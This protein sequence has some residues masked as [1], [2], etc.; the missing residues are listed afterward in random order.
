MKNFR[1]KVSPVILFVFIALPVFAGA[2]VEYT[3]RP[4]VTVQESPSVKIILTWPYFTS[5]SQYYILRKALADTVWADI[6]AVA[7][8]A[9]TWADTTAAVGTIYEYKISHGIANSYLVSA[10]KAPLVD[11]RG[12]VILIVDNTMTAPLLAEL[13]RLEQDLVGDGWTVIRHDVARAASVPSVKTLIV[14]DYNADP[15]NVKAVF[16]FGRVPVPYSGDINPDGHPDHLGA[17]PADVFYA[18]VDGTWTDTTV[19]DTG[20]SRAENKNIP[21]DGKYDQSYIPSNTELEIGRV[22]LANMTAFSKTETELLRQ[23]LDKDHNFRHGIISCQRRAL[24]DDEFGDIYNENFASSGWRNFASFFGASNV[25]GLDW[26]TTLNTNDY[27]CAYGCGGGNYTSASNVG[28][29]TDFVNTDTKVVFTMLFGSYF[30][31]WDSTNNFLRAPLCTTTY[32]LTCLWAGRPHWYIQ[33]MGLGFEIGYGAKL[34]QNNSFLYSPVNYGGR[35]VHVALMG[36]PTLRLHI[37]KPVTNLTGVLNGSTNDIDVAWT[38]PVGE[39]VVG[40]HVYRSDDPAGP[41]TRLTTSVVTGTNYSD[42]SPLSGDN[43]Y[44]V[45]TVKLESSASGTYYNASQGMFVTVAS[46][47]TAPTVHVTAARLTGTVS[48]DKYCP[49]EIVIDGTAYAAG[50]N[51]TWQSGD[52]TL[53]PGTNNLTITAADAS[54]NTRTVQLSIAGVE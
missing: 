25:V 9:T 21:G 23:Y 35:G 48:D 14:N 39:T 29:T 6:G 2:P 5:G 47:T 18:D 32:G 27:L 36:D 49:R 19:N 10:I 33:S 16:L 26:F 11:S 34:T 24:I 40:Y 17:W 38:A 8:T 44:M 20:A 12:K 22:D 1:F 50:L 3:V 52:V 41:F 7:D 54:A 42:T 30:G 31:D 4:S 15:A 45:R 13:T 37:V 43:T 51:G 53:I 28:S 46:D